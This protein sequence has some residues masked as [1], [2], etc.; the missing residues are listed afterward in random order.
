MMFSLLPMAAGAA[1]ALL[2]AAFT[3]LPVNAQETGKNAPPTPPLLTTNLAATP[4]AAAKTADDSLESDGRVPFYLKALA[5]AR[6]EAA[7]AFARLFRTT[8]FGGTLPPHI[9]AAMGVQVAETCRSPY[10]AA[11]LRR[12]ARALKTEASRDPRLP[13]AVRYADDLTQNVNGISQEKFTRIRTQFNDVQIVELTMTTCFFNYFARLT[14]GLRL[15][16]E[17]WLA[18][19]SPRLPR[20][21]TNPF[22]TARI[23][24]LTDA[25]MEGVVELQKSGANSGL[26]VGIP[27]SRRAMARVPD[28]SSAWWEYMQ[29]AR[30]NDEVPRTTLLQVSLAVSTLNG[31]RYCT[32]HQIVGLRKQGVEVGKLLSLQKEDS[33]LT[34]DEKA[35]VVF[36]RKLTKEPGEINDS[37]WAKLSAAFP[38]NAAMSVL[39]QTCTFAFMNRFT[40]TLNLPSEEEAI[41]IYQEVF[42]PAK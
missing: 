11:H 34:A 42:G 31:C 2:L 26:G 36:A 19:T 1:M 37:D 24:L 14:S 20:A 21:A 28:I 39:L 40:D 8:I 33:Q 5:E 9:K 3:S 4:P 13:L 10:A 16:P 30:K 15:T 23:A 6:P 29:A 12:L 27:N 32:V 17:T 41:H 7:P 18:T 22:A 35:A 25:E 38:G